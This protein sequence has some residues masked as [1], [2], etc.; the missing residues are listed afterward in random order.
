MFKIGK[1]AIFID[2]GIGL[3][4]VSEKV[5]FSAL[6]TNGETLTANPNL[7]KKKNTYFTLGTGFNLDI[8][9]GIKQ[10][11]SIV[12]LL[13]VKLSLRIGLLD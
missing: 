13:L 11:F 1:A 10:I 2:A 4:Q 6:T 8:V 5:K 7:K 9:D 12:I 3:T